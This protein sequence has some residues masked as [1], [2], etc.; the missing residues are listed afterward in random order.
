MNFSEINYPF[1]AWIML[2]N[3][4]K[5]KKFLARYKFYNMHAGIHSEYIVKN[6]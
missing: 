4:I 1:V 3:K 2:E 6:S 5:N